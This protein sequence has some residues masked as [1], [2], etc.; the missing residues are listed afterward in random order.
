MSIH[1][2]VGEQGAR[3]TSS[4][5]RLLDVLLS[6]PQRA[7]YL[8]G[9][10]VAARAGVHQ[11]SATKFAQRLGY[12]GYPDLRRDLQQDLLASASE[13]ITRTVQEA[14]DESLLEAL[15]RHEM[16]PLADLPRQV[17]QDQ[18]DRV[19]SL[20]LQARRRYVF[21]RG[22]ASVL[23][24]LLHRRMRRYGLLTSVLAASGRDLAEQLVAL[25]EGDVVVLFA[26]RRP[27]RY[28]TQ[29]LEVCTEVGA[30]AVVVTDTLAADSG[31]AA[32][33]IVASRGA[34]REFQ[35]LTVPTA[36]ANA[37]V[38]T[39]SRAAP[40]RTGQALDRLEALLDRFD[41]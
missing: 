35:S 3:L 27:P 40:Q 19:A 1:E 24:D 16:G 26:F 32:E 20:L 25:G 17:A 2:R 15:V 8:S 28:F 13:R 21:G 4:D 39:V 33:T 34:A 7:G 29:V 36:I 14:G 18:L 9:A 31:S 41:R 12:G 6:D 37:I 5:R 38:L 30:S 23:A 22:N 10:D 11:A